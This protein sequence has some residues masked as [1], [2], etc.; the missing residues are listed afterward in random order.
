MAALYRYF[1]D[2]IQRAASDWHRAGFIRP[3]WELRYLPEVEGL[4]ILVR[5]QWGEHKRYIITHHELSMGHP[6]VELDRW[7]HIVGEDLGRRFH[8]GDPR[9]VRLRHD[10]EMD[11]V[12]RYRATIRYG[13]DRTDHWEF[14]QTDWSQIFDPP[15]PEAERKSRDLFLAVAGPEAYKLMDA[16][17]PLP[18]TGSKGTKY[19]MFPVSTFNVTRVKDRARLCAVVPGVPLWDHLLGIKLM[20]EHDEP[21]FL[22]TANVSGGVP[23]ERQRRGGW[24]FGGI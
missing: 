12:R 14:Y 1:E 3:D 18:L 2:R 15:N 23:E 5:L 9:A 17:G 13:I 20:I 11:A 4:E 7:L 19:L 10:D 6:E 24:R 16:G 21:K 8:W 22:K